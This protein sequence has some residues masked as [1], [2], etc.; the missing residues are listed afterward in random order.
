[1]MPSLPKGVQAKGFNVTI[2]DEGGA[3]TPTKP[4]IMSGF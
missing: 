1:M 2:E 4:I 3:Q